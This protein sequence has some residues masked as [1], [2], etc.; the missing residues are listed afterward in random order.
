[1][2]FTNP[3]NFFKPKNLSAEDV[4]KQL[5][6]GLLK[7]RWPNLKQFKYFPKFLSRQEKIILA[8]AALVFLA[9]FG[10]L[11]FNLYE[12]HLK[13]SPDFGG[14]YIEGMVGAPQYIN[15]IYAS[16]NSVDA[17]LSRLV[18]ASLFRRAADGRLVNDLVAEEEISADGKTYTF[19]LTNKAHFA[20]GD[21]VTVDDVVFTFN[22]I[23]EAQ[24][25]SPL[26][27]N[28]QGVNIEKVDDN[29]L[30]FVLD[31]PYAPFKE[32]LTFGILPQSLWQD[33]SPAGMPLAELNLKPIG[34]GPY[35]FGSLIKDK[36]GN[37]K[38]YTLIVNP[39]YHLNEPYLEKITVR[40]Y[41]TEEEA[42]EALNNGKVDGLSYLPWNLQSNI[43][44]A[45]SLNL[46]PLALPQYTAAFF[47]LNLPDDRLSK[48]KFRQA[49]SLATDKSLLNKEIFND[50]ATL[51][52]GP[53]LPN[54]PAY[55]ANEKNQAYNPDE[56]KKILNE[57]GWLPGAADAEGKIWLTKNN[58]VLSLTISTPNV[59]ELVAAGQ[60]LQNQ[61]EKIGLKTNLEI[62]DSTELAGVIQARSFSILLNNVAVGLDADPFPL[63]HSSQ[64]TGEGYNLSGY[65][66]SQADK[67]L[68]QARTESDSNKR[69][70]LYGE[71]QKLIADDYPAIFLFSQPYVYPQNKSLK[72]FGAKI[73][74]SPEDRFWDVLNWHVKE[75]RKLNF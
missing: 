17:S 53:I 62:L 75:D 35:Q 61:W 70:A 39:K 1:V 26:R 49:L 38:S 60:N 40:F 18:Y 23:K 20:T 73:V 34:S 43:A 2:R 48:V 58:T 71:F 36:N 63:W 42:I 74:A 21:S 5:V 41:V 22:T 9:T 12:R 33:I 52:T 7:K 56:A 44:A 28:F 30:R 50:Q 51:L 4:D 11:G 8:S 66:N 31:E 59:A 37:I 72:G 16:L 10:W 67:L 27:V 47:N 24:Y 69:Y 14:E 3:L 13:I 25:R 29:K 54:N 55:I 46:H 32:L 68:G 19:E 64:A 57:L 45:N 65:K 15:P 6:L